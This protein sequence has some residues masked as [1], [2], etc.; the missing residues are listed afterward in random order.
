MG[1]LKQFYEKAFLQSNTISHWRGLGITKYEVNGRVNG[2][3]IEI[4]SCLFNHF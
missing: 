2:I 4:R 3:G 1:F